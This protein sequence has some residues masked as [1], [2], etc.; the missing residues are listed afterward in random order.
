[1]TPERDPLLISKKAYND[2]F[3]KLLE[4]LPGMY[5]AFIEKSL[6]A[7]HQDLGVLTKGVQGSFKQRPIFMTKVEAPREKWLLAASQ[8]KRKQRRKAA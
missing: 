7:F 5:V 4:F 1:M 3:D 2:N 8:Q 6:V